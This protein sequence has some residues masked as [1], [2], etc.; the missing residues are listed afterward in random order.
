MAGTVPY[1]TLLYT[2]L[3]HCLSEKIAISIA[4]RIPGTLHCR[5][6]PVLVC[7][8]TRTLVVCPYCS[9]RNERPDA[10]RLCVET[11]RA[12]L[13]LHRRCILNSLDATLSVLRHPQRRKLL[14]VPEALLNLTLEYII[15]LIV[16]MVVYAL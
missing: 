16:C 5:K 4:A 13:T 2:L 11:L 6:G 7:V 14:Y 1:C 9:P 12:V 10:I 3:Y 15:R 8:Q